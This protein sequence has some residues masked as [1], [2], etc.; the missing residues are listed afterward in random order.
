MRMCCSQKTQQSQTYPPLI[1]ADMTIGQAAGKQ[2]LLLNPA[3]KLHLS[4]NLHVF[5]PRKTP[6]LTKECNCSRLRLTHEASILFGNTH[7]AS[8][9]LW[10]ATTA[11]AIAHAVGCLAKMSPSLCYCHV[12]QAFATRSKPVGRKASINGSHMDWH[13]PTT[14]VPGW[15]TMIRGTL[16]SAH[17]S[18]ARPHARYRQCQGVQACCQHPPAPQRK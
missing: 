12:Q 2:A 8:A 5:Q 10:Q 11:A 15:H 7:A 9:A 17:A 13:H 3:G 16:C 1:V 4:N 6:M 18:L 14:T